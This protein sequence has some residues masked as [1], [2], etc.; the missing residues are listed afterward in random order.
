MADGCGA[1]LAGAP[2]SRPIGID[3]KTGL[4]GGMNL[5]GFGAGDPVNLEDCV[6]CRRR[7]QVST[8]TPEGPVCA[9][10]N[11]PGILTCSSCGRIAPCTV[12]KITGQPRCV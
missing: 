9:T 11:P 10:C 7:R 3:T 12:S 5:Y 4:A 1:Q 8:R 2:S 6:C